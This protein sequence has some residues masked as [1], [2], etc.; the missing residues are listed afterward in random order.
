MKLIENTYVLR[1]GPIAH[2][3]VAHTHFP[4]GKKGGE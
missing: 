3:D 2:M 4:G 1:S